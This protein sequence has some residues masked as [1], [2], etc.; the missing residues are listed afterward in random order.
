MGDETVPTNAGP[1]TTLSG[2]GAPN[3]S[4]TAQTAAV[5]ATTNAAPN[6]VTA[7]THPTA[8]TTTAGVAPNPVTASQGAS[9]TN[10][11][12]TAAPVATL[13]ATTMNST[14]APLA[15]GPFNAIAPALSGA[16]STG[17]PATPVASSAPRSGSAREKK[18]SRKKR[19]AKGAVAAGSKQA[20][21]AFKP[22]ESPLRFRLDGKVSAPDYEGKQVTF[23]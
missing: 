11:M 4:A 18:D 19:E 3:S 17:S 10:P 14:P 15:G 9:G 7:A 1:S 16:V 23:I 5:T 8:T 20:E 12:P 13:P 6:S 2:N 21:D 22:V